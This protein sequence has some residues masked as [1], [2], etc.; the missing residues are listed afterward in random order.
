MTKK[1]LTGK[2]AYAR[3][4]AISAEI[5][6]LYDEQTALKEQFI[7][8]DTRKLAK[9]SVFGIRD[10]LGRLSYHV[11]VGHRAIAEAHP[12]EKKTTVYATAV[13]TRRCTK[14]G[15]PTV[16][17]VREFSASAV[18]SAIIVQKGSSK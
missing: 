8:E 11:V 10:E 3:S 7:K 17:S 4:T 6:R 2:E 5:Q 15:R 13:R 14:C 1:K 12:K 16:W 18:K 9:G